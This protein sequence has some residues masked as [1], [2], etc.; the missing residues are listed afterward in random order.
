MY[1]CASF[2]NPNPNWPVS[3]NSSSV[4]ICPALNANEIQIQIQIPSQGVL[5]GEK[6]LKHTQLCQ[7][8]SNMKMPD[9]PAKHE[10]LIKQYLR[11]ILG[12]SVE[13]RKNI[14][15]WLIIAVI[16]ATEAD[17]KLKPEKIQAWTGFE[18]MTSAIYFGIAEVMGSNRHL[19]LLF[20]LG[21]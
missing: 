4:Q 19:F 13:L 3:S 6:T 14:N 8:W 20:L 1:N 9:N 7:I 18:P 12:I 5:I 16:H 21:S 15:Y 11:S 10:V 17:V 2:S